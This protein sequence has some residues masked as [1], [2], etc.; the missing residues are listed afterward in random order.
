MAGKFVT[1][2]SRMSVLLSQAI[3]FIISER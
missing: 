1:T 3:R 2:M